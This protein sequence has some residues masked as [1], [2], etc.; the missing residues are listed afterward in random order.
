MDEQVGGGK[1]CGDDIQSFLVSGSNP[2]YF[3]RYSNKY[4]GYLA[5]FPVRG[6]A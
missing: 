2:L 6:T 4:M 3:D 5:L 1:R